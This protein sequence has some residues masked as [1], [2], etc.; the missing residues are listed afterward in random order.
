[1]VSVPESVSKFQY[2]LS[3]HEPEYV[4]ANAE[5][6]IPAVMLSSIATERNKLIIFFIKLPPNTKK[7]INTATLTVNMKIID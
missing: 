1:M 2:T 6:S 5:R 3:P 7:H 4:S